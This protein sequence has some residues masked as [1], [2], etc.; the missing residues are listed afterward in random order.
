MDRKTYTIGKVKQLIDL[1]GDST[2]FRIALKIQTENNTPFEMLIVDQ[3]TLDNNPNIEYKR[4]DTGE[5]SAEVEQAQNIYQNY[6]LILK[7]D[8]ECKCNVE[9]EKQELP[10][11]TE[12]DRII[13]LEKK[14]SNTVKYIIYILIACVCLYGGYLIYK[15]MSQKTE[16]YE[17]MNDSPMHNSPIHDSPDYN[18]SPVRPNTFNIGRKYVTPPSKSFDLPPVI[19]KSNPILDKLKKL[20]I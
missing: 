12:L 2:N 18:F 11:N 15:K 4:I 14:E 8:K 20:K 19:P 9:I 17:S 13:P 5:L 3:T 16:K 7:A 10:K 6:F 1:N